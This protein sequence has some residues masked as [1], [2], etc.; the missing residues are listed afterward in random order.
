M[1]QAEE[2]VKEYESWR[3]ARRAEGSVGRGSRLV[4][5]WGIPFA[6][7]DSAAVTFASWLT[8]GWQP[9]SVALAAVAPPPR[10]GAMSASSSRKPVIT[11]VGQAMQGREALAGFDRGV[12][13]EWLVWS[14]VVKLW[15]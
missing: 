12:A 3:R 13:R 10:A 11:R 2:I 5:K 15:M 8:S 6:T 14:S 7:I 1:E 9:M 4:Q